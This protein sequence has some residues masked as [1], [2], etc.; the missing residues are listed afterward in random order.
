M[1]KFMHTIDGRPAFYD[2]E[3]QICFA[4]RRRAIPLAKDL[5][6]IK[7][8]QRASRRWRIKNGFF[9]T[10]GYGFMRIET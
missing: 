1:T 10:S 5:N 3:E 7:R 2:H 8:E 4:V 6:Q 9:P